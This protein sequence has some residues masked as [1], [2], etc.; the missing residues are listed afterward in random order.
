[1]QCDILCTRTLC[2]KDTICRARCN[3][4]RNPFDVICGTSSGAINASALACGSDQ[5]DQTLYTL[6]NVW[7]KFHVNQVYRSDVLDMVRSGARW[8]SLITLG[9]T[10]RAQ[11]MRPKSLLDNT[12]LANLLSANID[13][14]R[15]P[16]LLAQGRGVSAE[17]AL[18]TY[19]RDKV[20]QTTA[21]RAAIKAAQ[22][23]AT[24]A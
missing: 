6:A 23:A 24:A 3:Q 2:K 9:W 19:I 7:E 18:P 20:A 10:I 5:F 17:H 21:E 12:P 22:V 1:M 16:Q 14:S 8:L 13:F 4:T 15:L 11:N